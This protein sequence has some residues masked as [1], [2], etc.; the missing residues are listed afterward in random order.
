MSTQSTVVPVIDLFA[1]AGGLG[2]GFYALRA[3]GGRECFDLKLSIEKDVWAHQTLELRA[4]F[5]QFSSSQVPSKYYD[6]LRGTTDTD[7][8]YA[9]FPEQ[10]ASAAAAAWRAELGV[11]PSSHVHR[12]INEA[13]ADANEWVFIGGP[14]FLIFS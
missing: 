13:L 14:P 9:Q 3:H 2:E 5:R 12:R 8:L 10:A 7:S 4:C 1:G 6:V 11:T